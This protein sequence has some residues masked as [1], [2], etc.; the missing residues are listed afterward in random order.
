M[1]LGNNERVCVSNNNYDTNSNCNKIRF[2]LLCFS[3]LSNNSP[4]AAAAAA[5]VAVEHSS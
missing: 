2:L 3:S 5:I 1:T 4:V